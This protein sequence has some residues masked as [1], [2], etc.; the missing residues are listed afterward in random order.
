MRRPLAYREVGGAFT[1]RIWRP[2]ISWCWT[3]CSSPSRRSRA[4]HA[5]A[6]HVAVACEPAGQGLAHSQRHV[7]DAAAALRKYDGQWVELT[8]ARRL[9]GAAHGSQNPRTT[10]KASP[11]TCRCFRAALLL[12]KP[13]PVGSRAEILTAWPR[14]TAGTAGS[15]RPTCVGALKSA[16]PPSL[17]SVPDASAFRLPSTRHS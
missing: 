5:A 2:P 14:A 13:R 7:R 10:R 1:R 15:R 8:V 3:K 12:P 6:V 11:T 4:C 9:P 17:A 16:L